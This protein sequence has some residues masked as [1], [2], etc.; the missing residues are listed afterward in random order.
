MFMTIS[1]HTEISFTSL[2]TTDC[3]KDSGVLMQTKELFHPHPSLPIFKFKPNDYYPPPPK[4]TLTFDLNSQNL[5][6]SEARE[7]L[8]MY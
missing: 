7:V 5:L 3:T 4:K 1:C 8:A 6:T 2:E